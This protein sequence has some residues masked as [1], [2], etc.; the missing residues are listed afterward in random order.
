MTM[1]DFALDEE[2]T[3]KILI[4]IEEG[5][6]IVELIESDMLEGKKVEKNQNLCDGKVKA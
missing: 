6:N 1:N 3:L 4:D 5:S 2:S